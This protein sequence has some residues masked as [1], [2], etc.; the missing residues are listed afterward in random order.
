MATDVLR[1]QALARAAFQEAAETASNA[2]AFREAAEAVIT[3]SHAASVWAGVADRSWTGRARQWLSGILGERALPK[4]DRE[5]L[6]AT[7]R[8]QRRYLD[9]FMRDWDNLSE[10]QRRARA[11]LYAGPV[12]TTYEQA[13]WGDWALPFYPGEGSECKANCRCSW[14]V[15]DLGNGRGRATWRL[16]SAEHCPTCTQRAAQ[17]PYDVRRNR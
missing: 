8:E 14:Q 3:R 17:S 2:G 11:A 16:S 1:L 12:R 13:R 9:G 10:A 5:A 6:K 15:E 4:A 7:I